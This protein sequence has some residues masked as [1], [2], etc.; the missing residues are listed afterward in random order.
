MQTVS[1]KML[2]QMNKLKV[3][4]NVEYKKGPW[5]GGNLFI[6]NLQ[7]YLESSGHEVIFHLFDSDIDIILIIDPRMLSEA[8][9][10][11]I[12]DVEFYK[13][14]INTNCKIVHRINEC[15]E[16][17]NTAGM[18][19]YYIDAN[20]KVADYT[21]FVSEWLKDIFI[22]S[23]FS[24]KNSKVIMSGANKKV[25]NNKGRAIWR[26]NKPLRIVTHHW[27]NNSNKGFDI[28]SF[29]DKKIK[30]KYNNELIFTYIGNLKQDL[31]L[32]STI[33]LKP[34]SGKKLANLL[35]ENHIYLTASVNEP[36]GNHHIEGAQCGLP[37]LYRNSGGIPEFAKGYGVAFEG[38]DDFFESL[39]TLKQ[40]F[41]DYHSKVQNYPFNSQD[42]CME[43]LDLFQSLYS[44]TS[45]NKI[46]VKTILLKNS[47]E[48]LFYFLNKIL[49]SINLY[50]LKVKIKKYILIKI[51]LLKR[52]RNVV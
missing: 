44:S 3:S 37:I 51:P 47:L 48:K 16:R 40:N 15:D 28:Y 34:E 36:S 25:F 2:Y 33:V 35:K 49:N 9:S 1:K 39:E 23:G 8:V 20:K 13:R 6:S 46:K 32:E 18:N 50:K 10:Y 21:V 52:E 5:G 19:E 45:E 42:M 38:V 7:K 43:Y 4:I 27:G 17:K 24:S 41:Q 29:L 14:N 12:K 26:Q 11:S 30:E 22:K 31:E